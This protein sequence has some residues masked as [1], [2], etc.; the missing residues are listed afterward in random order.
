MN[1]AMNELLHPHSR[2]CILCDIIQ[3]R[4]NTP[5]QE[6]MTG[7]RSNDQIILRSEF[8]MLIVDVAPIARAHCLIIPLKHRTSLASLTDKE[9]QDVIATKNKIVSLITENLRTSVVVFEHGETEGCLAQHG[10]SIHHAHLHIAEWR[11]A[12]LGIPHITEANLTPLTNGLNSLTNCTTISNSSGYIYFE[13]KEIGAWCSSASG[14]APQVLR[15]TFLDL[16][17]TEHHEAWNW[18]D[19]IVMSEAFD[20]QRRVQDNLLILKGLLI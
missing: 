16:E 4:E 9:L 19:Q 2:G 20:T 15:R 17:W 8:S 3:N 5:F 7:Y 11:T 1:L 13:A 18:S 10:C 12:Y 14:L 6:L